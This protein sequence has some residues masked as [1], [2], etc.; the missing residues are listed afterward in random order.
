[1][2]PGS[3]NTRS[4]VPGGTEYYSPHSL[5]PSARPPLFRAPGPVQADTSGASAAG[6]NRPVE[7]LR[8]PTDNRSDSGCGSCYIPLMHLL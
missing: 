7:L 3:A 1:M 4:S 2:C 6:C 8:K 5:L